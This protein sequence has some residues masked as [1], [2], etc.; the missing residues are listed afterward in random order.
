MA[1][2]YAERLEDVVDIHFTTV[3]LALARWRPGVKENAAARC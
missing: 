2:G 3:A 1:G